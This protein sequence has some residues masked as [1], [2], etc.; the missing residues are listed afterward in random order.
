[1]EKK[2]RVRYACKHRKGKTVNNLEWYTKLLQFCHL[3]EQC[4][5]CPFHLLNAE[6]S[7]ERRYCL[8]SEKNLLTLDAWLATHHGE[9]DEEDEEQGPSHEDDHQWLRDLLRVE[10]EETEDT[11]LFIEEDFI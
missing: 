8:N 7:H 4:E 3:S 10:F 6:P 2:S 1:M 9:T 11:D 5:T